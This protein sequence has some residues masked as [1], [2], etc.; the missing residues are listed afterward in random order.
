MQLEIVTPEKIIYQ[1]EVDEIVVTTADG[2]IAVLPHHVN[3]FTKVLPGE[4]TMKIGGKEQFLAIT[5]G[6]LE[7]SDNK[8]SLLADYAV[9]AEEIEVEKALE[10]QKRA[11]EILKSKESGLTE[12]D[13]ATAQGDLRRAI[14]E[15]HVARRRHHSNPQVKQ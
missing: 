5:G 6:F 11:E 8:I 4:L 10:A 12:R 3:L 15:L 14:L 1:G 13:F 9:R 2:E 7:I